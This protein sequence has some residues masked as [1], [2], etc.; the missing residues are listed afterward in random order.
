MA[1]RIKD[2]CLGGTK[3]VVGGIT[4]VGWLSGF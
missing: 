2:W 3:L 1:D 4:L